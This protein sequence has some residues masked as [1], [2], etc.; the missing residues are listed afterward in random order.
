MSREE[1]PL[2]LSGQ[3]LGFALDDYFDGAYMGAFGPD[4]KPAG[5]IFTGHESDEHE[6]LIGV[7]HVSAEWPGD[8]ADVE[9][10]LLERVVEMLLDPDSGRCSRA[11]AALYSDQEEEE[12]NRLEEVYARLGFRFFRDSRIYARDLL[13]DLPPPAGR[14]SYESIDS[15]GDRAFADICA[16]SAAGSD[17]AG[18]DFGALV[19]R[20]RRGLRFDPELFRVAY[21]RRETGGKVPVGV[22]MARL[23]L[24]VP[25]EAAFYYIG[26]LPDFRAS[27]YGSELLLEC[28]ALLRDRGAVRTREIVPSTSK[29]AISLLTKH[30]YR[31]TEWARYFSR[32]A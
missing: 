16:R 17:F 1:L 4:G 8:P 15:V 6:V 2:F 23:D 12:R 28:L 5:F 13:D 26:V 18:T 21:D 29:S 19:S 30:G 25:S 22:F 24:L 10:Y 14:L 11:I 20:Y 27:G 7:P 32:E 9:S 3:L 31:L